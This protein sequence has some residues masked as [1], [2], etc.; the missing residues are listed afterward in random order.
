LNVTP[1]ERTLAVDSEDRTMAFVDQPWKEL[2]PLLAE[3]A[4]VSMVTATVVL[5]V[6]SWNRARLPAVISPPTAAARVTPDPM[7]PAAAAAV[8]K[9]YVERTLGAPGARFHEP[10]VAKRIGGRAG[11]DGVEQPRYQAE[12]VVDAPHGAGTSIR[13]RFLMTL[14]YAGGQWRIE[15]KHVATNFAPTTR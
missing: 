12:V 10:I 9:S 1:I 6:Q 3:V 14:R 4:T 11:A 7:S 5:L 8:A 13:S 2:A 15:R